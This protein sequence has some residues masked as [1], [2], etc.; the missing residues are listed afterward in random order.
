MT[1]LR[2]RVSEESARNPGGGPCWAQARLPKQQMTSSRPIFFIPK[3]RI[4]FITFKRFNKPA[5]HSYAYEQKTIEF[6]RS[7]H[8]RRESGDRD[9]NLSNTGCGGCSGWYAGYFFS[10]LGTWRRDRAL[11]GAYICG[12]WF[13]LS[14][15]GRLLQDLF[16]GL[17]SLACVFHQLYRAG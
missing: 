13:P 9:G 15:D 3:F 17:S 7:Q 11:R 6:I 4:E 2:G 14:G 16:V 1:S 12:D 5:C 10:G 8:D